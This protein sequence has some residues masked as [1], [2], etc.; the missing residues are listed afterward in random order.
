M[1]SVLYYLRLIR[2]YD[3]DTYLH[4]NRVA[5]F[6][7]YIGQEI[8][9]SSKELD[10]LLNVARLHDLGKVKIDKKILH[11]PGK[12]DKEE[13]N[14][15]CKHSLYGVEML[16]N[17]EELRQVIE[18]VYSHHEHFN[19]QGYPRGLRGESINIYA[20]VISIADAFD[21]MTT[22][23]IYRNSSLTPR[24]AVQEIMKCS[25]TQFD[26]NITKVLTRIDPGV[27]SFI[28]Q[29]K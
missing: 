5:E 11:K 28:K 27:L 15:I 26:P 19:G 12:L 1:G 10:Q 22:N 16:S 7:Y 9:L 2:D 21:A 18:A 25:G 6:A 20:R 17:E 3:Y 14:E 29:L 8:A 23:R 24:Q 13:W 4:C